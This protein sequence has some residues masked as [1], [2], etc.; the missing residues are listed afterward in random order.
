MCLIKVNA[1]AE[2]RAEA[3]R[4]ADI[5][6]ARVVDSTVKTYTFQVTGD[7]KKLAAFIDLLRPIGI[8]EIVRTGKVA[9][10]RE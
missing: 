10:T 5:F 3:L 2:H 8:K 6:R 1:A 4:I 7:E 9:I